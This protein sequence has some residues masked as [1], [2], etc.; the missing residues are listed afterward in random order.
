MG[1]T[2]SLFEQE[3]NE[4][5]QRLVLYCMENSKK[6][7]EGILGKEI[8]YAFP[9][10]HEKHDENN[11]PC[12]YYDLNCKVER[13]IP[14]YGFYDCLL[15]LTKNYNF[16]VKHLFIIEC[17]GFVKNAQ[18]TLRQLNAYASYFSKRDVNVYRILIVDNI[19]ESGLKEIDLK[20]LKLDGVFVF[21]ANLEK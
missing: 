7:V 1:V 13:P 14:F 10:E 8:V 6:I 11:C 19:M 2:S 5:H 15:T 9:K 20:Y 21:E 16:E 3:T 4:K 18:D 17:K 12:W